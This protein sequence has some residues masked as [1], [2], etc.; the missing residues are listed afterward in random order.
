MLPFRQRYDVMATWCPSSSQKKKKNGG[1]FCSASN[2]I[3]T[4]TFSRCYFPLSFPSK[5]GVV[6]HL[7]HREACALI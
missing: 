4:T 7:L 6:C 1:F 5:R 2:K 3:H